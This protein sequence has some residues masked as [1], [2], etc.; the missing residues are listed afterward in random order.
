MQRPAAT[1]GRRHT[2]AGS[3]SVAELIKQQPTPMRILSNEEAATDAL[4]T[5]LLGPTENMTATTTVIPV[6]PGR[7]RRTKS[8]RLAR[9]A[10]LLTGAIVLVSS[11]AGAA[12]LANKRPANSGVPVTERPVALSGSSALRPDV[13]SAQLPNERTPVATTAVPMPQPSALLLQTGEP[14]L[15]TPEVSVGPQPQVDVVKRFYELLTTKPGSAAKLL[16]PELVGANPAEFVRSWGTV[17]TVNVDQ[18][19][20]RPDGSVLAVVSMQET[21]GSWLRIEQ[22]FW[23]TSTSQ[24]RIVG[25]E[26]LSAQRS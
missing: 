19:S 3:I 7:R 12:I 18:T 11:I 10:G 6:V 25:T 16:S 24:P 17:K 26:V 5:S 14:E 15:S 20:V 2:R 1:T 23:L 13:L 21:D 9:A 22:L 8:S 4:V